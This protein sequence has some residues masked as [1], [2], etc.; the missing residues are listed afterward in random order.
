MGKIFKELLK[1]IEQINSEDK[2]GFEKLL[3]QSEKIFSIGF[4]KL[5]DKPFHKVWF[6]LKTNSILIKIKE[7]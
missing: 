6:M 7:L 2:K 1:E 3:I 5:A 4:L